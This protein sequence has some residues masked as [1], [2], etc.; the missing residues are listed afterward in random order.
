M[1]KFTRTFHTVGQGAFYSEEIDF[2]N[3]RVFRMV[4]DCGSTSLSKPNLIKRIKSDFEDNLDIDILFI[5]HFHKDHINGI[6]NLKPKLIVIPFLTKD[7][8]FLLKLYNKLFKNTYDDKLA[9]NP[10]DFF[11]E[12]KVIRILPDNLESREQNQEIIYNINDSSFDNVYNNRLSS[13]ST[14][15]IAD[16]KSFWEY[17]P[18]NPNWNDYVDLFKKTVEMNKLEW[19]KLTDLSSNNLYIKENFSVLKKIYDKL[20]SKNLHSL[21]VYSNAKN[22]INYSSYIHNINICFYNF[23]GC[24]SYFRVPLGCIY[25]GDTTFNSELENSFYKY[26]SNSN[27][28]QQIGTLQVPHHGSY[29]SKGQNIISSK[30]PFNKKIFCIISVGESNNYGHPSAYVIKKLQDKQGIVFLVTETPSTLF[31]LEGIL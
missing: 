17:I 5:S 16:G 2:N 26:L 10:A 4:Y 23:R 27:R 19:N 18:Y 15:K 22:C 25:F 30:F 1:I 20:K 13:K 8:I 14:I 6:Y 24:F 28:L 9:E 21:V 11:P 3:K 29:L 31:Y 7:Q 12:A